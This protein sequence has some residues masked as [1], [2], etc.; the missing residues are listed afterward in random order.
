LVLH[1]DKS[2]QPDTKKGY[3]QKYERL[4]AVVKRVPKAILTDGEMLDWKVELEERKRR[5]TGQ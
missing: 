2:E 1:D 4:T 3:A 5:G